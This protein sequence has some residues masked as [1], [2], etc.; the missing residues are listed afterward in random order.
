MLAEAVVFPSLMTAPH[1]AAFGKWSPH[2]VNRAG[3]VGSSPAPLTSTRRAR[4]HTYPSVLS[5]LR[6][7]EISSVPPGG[8]AARM[9]LR[10]W[11]LATA[12]VVALVGGPAAA[13]GASPAPAAPAPATCD[14]PRGTAEGRPFPGTAIRPV[15]TV[16]AVMLF[17]DF[18]DATTTDDFTSYTSQLLPAKGWFA[19]SSY[20][21]LD[22]RITVKRQWFRMPRNSTAYHWARGLTFDQQKRY[23][24]D[25][26]MAADHAVDF[27]RYQIVYV[28]PAANA[29]AIF[30]SP[31]F[32]GGQTYGVK[33]DGTTIGFGATFGQDM[34]YFGSQVLNHETGHIFGLPDLYDFNSAGFTTDHRFVGYWDLMGW[35][36]GDAPDYFAWHKWHMGWI[37]SSD[38]VCLK[39]RGD[40]TVDLSPVEGATGTRLAIIRISST[41]VYGVEVRAAQGNDGA[42]CVP[43]VLVYRIRGDVDT[44]HGPVQVRTSHH[45]H[46]GSI[47]A[48]GPKENAT[49]QVGQSWSDPNVKVTVNG[50]SSDTTEVTLEHK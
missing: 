25:A 10:P 20:G 33:V 37:D 50:I 30:F 11:V 47:D 17:V 45:D 2:R 39:A 5:H 34:W 36:L 32:V 16:K 44:G 8:Y 3:Q 15:G 24:T 7:A 26:I 6:P 1:R 18:P 22:L 42:V 23:L 49:L 12:L 9:K 35:I 27:S 13:N 43:G 4:L 38:V 40:R 21:R 48:C 28:V 46:P 19:T 41:L 31:A 29:A 14:L